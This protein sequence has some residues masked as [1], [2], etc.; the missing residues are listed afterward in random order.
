MTL[1]KYPSNFG[2]SPVIY[3]LLFVNSANFLELTAQL[4]QS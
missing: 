3:I 4:A 1:I 2:Y